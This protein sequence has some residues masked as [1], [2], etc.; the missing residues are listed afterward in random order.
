MLLFR[1]R[2]YPLNRFFS[3]CVQLFVFFS[4]PQV[5]H[6]FYVIGPNVSAD[7]FGEI[8]AFCTLQQQRA[9]SASF[10]I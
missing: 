2:E 6:F 3:Q 8:P 4:M 5:I 7:S 9:V 10:G 1:I